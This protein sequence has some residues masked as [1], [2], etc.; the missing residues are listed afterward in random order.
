MYFKC[1]F[2]IWIICLNSQSTTL[3]NT[4]QQEHDLINPQS[5]CRSKFGDMETEVPSSNIITIFQIKTRFNNEH[6]MIRHVTCEE[7][8]VQLVQ[9]EFGWMTLFQDSA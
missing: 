8:I 6:W 1:I 5:G 9:S 4:S 7:K 3:A 2:K